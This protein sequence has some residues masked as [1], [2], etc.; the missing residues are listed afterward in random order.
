[1]VKLCNLHRSGYSYLNYRGVVKRE[2][3]EEGLGMRLAWHVVRN[4]VSH[5]CGLTYRAVD[6]EVHGDD[7]Q[8][9]KHIQAII[10][11]VLGNIFVQ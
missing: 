7:I 8:A 1:M 10:M 4:N 2:V 6:A 11:V 9:I 3:G 5:C